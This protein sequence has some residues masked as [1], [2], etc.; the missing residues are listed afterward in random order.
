M[1]TTLTALADKQAGMP[2]GAPSAA[3]LMDGSSADAATPPT[4]TPCSSSRSH[5]S[6]GSSGSGSGC[7]KSS[8]SRSGGGEA[9][10]RKVRRGGSVRG[11]AAWVAAA[12]R[13]V[14]TA[15]R[16]AQTSL[17]TSMRR[18][19]GSSSSSS[20]S[21][22]HCVL[23]AAAGPDAGGAGRH[24]S[25][26]R[27]EQVRE[28][29]GREQG[30]RQPPSAQEGGEECQHAGPGGADGSVDGQ[31]ARGALRP[32]SRTGAAGK[33]SP[34]A[35]EAEAVGRQLLRQ[36]LQ[37]SPSQAVA[38]L[39][40][41]TG[42]PQG[43][44][45]GGGGGGGSNAGA[46][47]ATAP[48]SSPDTTPAPPAPP[49]PPGPHCGG[50]ACRL[51]PAAASLL[52]PLGALP[53]AVASG[54]AEPT[55]IPAYLR[56]EC[57]HFDAARGLVT[58]PTA[59]LAAAA[60]AAGGGQLYG[61]PTP[62]AAEA[63]PPEAAEG[64]GGGGG[65]GGRRLSRT[66]TRG[67]SLRRI[68]PEV[69]GRGP[70]TAGAAPD[71]EEEGEGERQ[72]QPEP[73]AAAAAAG[74]R[75]PLTVTAWHDLDPRRP[76]NVLTFYGGVG[77]AVPY[78]DRSCGQ[79]AN[80][81]VAFRQ[82]F[83]CGAR[84]EGGVLPGWSSRSGSPFT[85][86]WIGRFGADTGEHE[87]WLLGLG[88]SKAG[89]ER[90]LFWS[91]HELFTYNTNTGFAMKHAFSEG[92]RPPSGE[93][94]FEALVRYPGATSAAFFR[95]SQSSRLARWPLFCHPRSV[96]GDSLSLGA[97]WRDWGNAPW[98]PKCLSGGAVAVVLVY[99]RALSG[100]DLQLL[101]SYYAPRFGFQA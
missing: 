33:T 97:D 13:A 36:L 7:S 1:R 48:T 89:Y 75:F 20:S 8:G 11:A 90:E 55:M 79:V 3:G 80:G 54:A 88:R 40:A 51:G 59:E 43:S 39:A 95:R 84:M 93:W 92:R 22:R 58:A 45:G 27:E 64:G 66:A 12:A 70:P 72:Q 76:D 91:S 2:G 34:A 100:A 10:G 17:R 31:A 24:M 99:N 85:L 65:G 94:T 6:D 16:A 96:S 25:Q 57:A 61:L 56:P 74:G 30:Q 83:G 87:Q 81:A 18:R 37:Q 82:G 41:A 44:S 28:E 63:L 47:T 26:V 21:S 52:A 4:L 50:A 67:R 101:S 23:G 86:V 53:A 46:A 9:A 32:A 42:A 77:G 19:G 78:I 60:A 29:Q 69:L 68:P 73:A 62:S 5:A 98:N 14:R 49:G 15:A 71:A 38:S 35:A